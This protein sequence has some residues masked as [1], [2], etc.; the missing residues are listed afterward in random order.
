MGQDEAAMAA[1]ATN[2]MPRNMKSPSRLR[3]GCAFPPI[4]K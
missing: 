3:L 1:A 2:I 4:C